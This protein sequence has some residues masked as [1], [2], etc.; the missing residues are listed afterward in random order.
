MHNTDNAEALSIE[1]CSVNVICSFFCTN[2]LKGGVLLGT[3]QN[4]RLLKL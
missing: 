4:Y 3:V 1:T 2:V